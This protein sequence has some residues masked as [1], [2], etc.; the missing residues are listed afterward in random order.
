MTTLWIILTVVFALAELLTPG[1]L[2]SVW[3]AVGAGAALAAL[4]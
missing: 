4:G 2:V 3:F 1:A